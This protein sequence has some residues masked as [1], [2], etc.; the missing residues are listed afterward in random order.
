MIRPCDACGG[1]Y[2]DGE[3]CRFCER[4]EAAYKRGLEDM[5]ERAAEECASREAY[6]RSQSGYGA[7]DS[8]I[9]D[10]ADEAE[11]CADSI[12]DLDLE[13][14]VEEKPSRHVCI[15]CGF[16]FRPSERCSL[17]TRA[18][19]QETLRKRRSVCQ[20]GSAAKD[21]ACKMDCPGSE[22]EP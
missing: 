19:D 15:D 1:V 22:V 9:S 2:Y 10:R 14:D 4:L 5:R 21:R 6:W 12:R 13:V 17:C 3:P 8:G 16:A 20:C 11:A 18:H 7:W